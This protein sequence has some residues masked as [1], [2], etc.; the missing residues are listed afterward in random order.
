MQSGALIP[1]SFPSQSIPNASPIVQTSGVI[2][3]YVPGSTG[4]YNYGTIQ[5]R[6]STLVRKINVSK[7]AYD[8]SGKLEVLV[9]TQLGDVGEAKLT[10]ITE[11]GGSD[12]IHYQSIGD[13]EQFSYVF[14]KPFYDSASTKSMYNVIR[15]GYFII[16]IL[17]RFEL[18]TGISGPPQ[19][20]WIPNSGS[21]FTHDDKREWV[22]KFENETNEKIEK[23]KQILSF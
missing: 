13:G 11:V 22:A 6:F 19:F 18:S 23:F 20:W 10:Y 16:S 9:A 17:A 8:R 12:V 4:G 3:L 15:L 14:L 5:N 2:H 7:Q 1:D 21:L